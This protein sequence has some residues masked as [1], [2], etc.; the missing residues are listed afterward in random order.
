MNERI[1]KLLK[2]SGVL[3]RH[4]NPVAYEPWYLDALEKFGELIVAEC[5]SVPYAM[6]D[7]AELNADIAV[8]I[9]RCIKEHFGIEDEQ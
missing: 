2:Q 9:D 1:E 4:F 3:D 8:K 7:R 5:V 6:W